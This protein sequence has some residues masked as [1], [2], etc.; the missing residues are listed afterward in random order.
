MYV[1]FRGLWAI[2]WDMMVEVVGTSPE[3]IVRIRLAMNNVTSLRN[4]LSRL[5]RYDLR[6]RRRTALPRLIVEGMYYPPDFQIAPFFKICGKTTSEDQR[7]LQEMM[8]KYPGFSLR[9]PKMSWMRVLELKIYCEHHRFVGE[10]HRICHE[11]R[12]FFVLTVTTDPF[13][14]PCATMIG[15]EKIVR[16]EMQGFLSQIA[17]LKVV[18][19]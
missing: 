10:A 11:K 9:K 14:K 6:F 16:N 15:L 8:T 4:F 2:F 17:S 13:E 19:F 1:L 12:V 7:H 18:F 3:T 5:R